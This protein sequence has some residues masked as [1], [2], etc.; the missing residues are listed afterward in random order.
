MCISVHFMISCHPNLL[1]NVPKTMKTIKHWSLQMYRSSLRS[2]IILFQGWVSSVRRCIL[3]ITVTTDDDSEHVD[4]AGW[5]R[6]DT[7]DFGEK[8]RERASEREKWQIFRADTKQTLH[9]HKSWEISQLN[10]MLISFNHHQI[11]PYFIPNALDI[12]SEYL[13]KKNLSIHPSCLQIFQ[14]P[15]WFVVSDGNSLRFLV[16][17]LLAIEGSVNT[18]A[19]VS[20]C[21]SA[22]QCNAVRLSGV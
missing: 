18:N 3:S 2:P 22:F 15:Y 21:I 7:T 16:F 11:N 12:C 9:L 17:L 10:I 6:T 13:L 19:E 5:R 20:F 8:W 1:S 4:I 14:S